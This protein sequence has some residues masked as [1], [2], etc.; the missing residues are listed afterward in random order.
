MRIEDDLVTVGQQAIFSV[1]INNY[2]PESIEN[3]RLKLDIG[4]ARAAANDAEFTWH[5]ID[6]ITLPR[7]ERG[8]VMQTFRHEFKEPG[9]Y[10]VRATLQ[11]K[12]GLDIDDVR[13]VVLTV[14]KRVEVLV[15]NG[16]SDG[17][18]FKQQ[19]AGWL[20]FA[21]D[22]DNGNSA[23]VNPIHVTVLTMPNLMMR[24]WVISRIT[25][26]CFS[27]TCRR[28]LRRPRNG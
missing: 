15:V 23:S 8:S 26:A 25:I 11:T 10:A 24:L 22:P 18:P 6:P 2:G 9:D 28:F 16:K 20:R 17:H 5:S 27:A 1:Q 21:L 14:K 7:V 3:V 12:D 13:Q 4:R 19:S